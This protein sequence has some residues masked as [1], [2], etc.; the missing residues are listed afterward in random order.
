M[1]CKE[2]ENIIF[3]IILPKSK[4]IT[5]GIFYRPPNQANFMELIIK[6]FSFKSDETKYIFL[7]ILTLIFYK[8]EIIF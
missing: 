3:D 2:I 6:S 7:V 1:N 8:T 5:L 4:P